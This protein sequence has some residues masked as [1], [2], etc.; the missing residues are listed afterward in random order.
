MILYKS[1]YVFI[2]YFIDSHI[3]RFVLVNGSVTSWRQ[4]AA[5][6]N[7]NPN[8]DKILAA[9]THP[10]TSETYRRQDDVTYVFGFEL[11]R[12][13][14][15]LFYNPQG[16]MSV[17]LLIYHSHQRWGSKRFLDLGGMYEDKLCDTLQ[18]MTPTNVETVHQTSL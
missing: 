6:T 15:N 12:L 10:R 2:F 18:G 17:V 5:Q 4:P 11:Q 3:Q 16:K 13:V 7:W 1:A 14:R 9:S 8:G